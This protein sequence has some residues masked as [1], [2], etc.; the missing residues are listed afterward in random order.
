MAWSSGAP[1]AGR[2][3]SIGRMPA[4]PSRRSAS[5]DRAWVA[6]HPAE[7]LE[8]T[9]AC[10]G[11]QRICSMANSMPS[12]TRSAGS[13]MPARCASESRA[14]ASDSRVSTARKMASWLP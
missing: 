1:S 14:M 12:T 6:A 10:T 13:S 2:S 11:R 7:S 8:N 9:A 3:P 4:S 5:T